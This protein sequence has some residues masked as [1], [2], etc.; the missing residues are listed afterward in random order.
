MVLNKDIYEIIFLIKDAIEDN[1]LSNFNNILLNNNISILDINNNQFD[2]LIYAIE[3]EVSIEFIK[4]IISLYKSLNYF[5]I[6]DNNEY[7]SPLLASLSINNLSIIELLINNGANTNFN[8][9]GNDIVFSFCK[10]I[11]TNKIKMNLYKRIFK[12]I[13]KHGYKPSKNL[14][15]LFLN[16]SFYKLLLNLF[17]DYKLSC[18]YSIEFITNLLFMYKNKTKLSKFKFKK[19]LLKERSKVDI[20]IEWFTKEKNL[21]CYSVIKMLSNYIQNSPKH[22]KKLIEI[23]YSKKKIRLLKMLIPKYFDVNLPIV[24]G[25]TLF[26]VASYNSDSN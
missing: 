23:L 1:N 2:I 22:S 15:E 5:I 3:N 7:K 19:M 26:D 18:I 8:I 24:K 25:E 11:L 9:C 13:L 17:F 10:D 14:I 20:N 21:N 6:T 4:Y 16:H 12:Y